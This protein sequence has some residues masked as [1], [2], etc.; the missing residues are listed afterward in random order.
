[1]YKQFYMASPPPRLS[2]FGLRSYVSQSGLAGVLRLIREKGVPTA[3]SRR[4]VKRSRQDSTQLNTAYGPLIKSFNCKGEIVEYIDPAALLSHTCVTCHGFSS[5]METKLRE[6]PSDLCNQWGLII[7]LDEV[8]PGNQLRHDN[9]RKIYAVYYSFVQFG[10]AA[11][12]CESCWMV[13]MVIRSSRVT[14]LGGMGD[15]FPH[16]LSCFFGETNLRTGVLLNCQGTSRLICASLQIV[17]ADEAAL[18]SVWE[19]KGSG[20][21]LPCLFC[22]NCVLDRSHL[23]VH[24]A[25][26]QLF[27]LSEPDRTKFV[28][29]DD[30]SIQAIV[31]YLSAQRPVLSNAGFDRLE[32]TLGFNHKPDGVLWSH[33]F[34]HVASPIQNTMYDWMHT[35]CVHGIYNIEVGLLLKVLSGV[36]VTHVTIHQ[37]LQTVHWPHNISSRA[38]SGQNAFAKRPSVISSP[39]ACSASEALGIYSPIRL[40][41]INNVL[42]LPHLRPAVTKA[43]HSYFCLAEVLDHLRAVSHGKATPAGLERAIDAHF[44]ASLDAYGDE[45]VTPKT[46][47]AVHLPEQYCLHGL[48]VNCFVHERKHR[49]LKRFGNHL[50]NTSSHFERTLIESILLCQLSI[51]EDESEFP[52]GPLLIKPCLAPDDLADIVQSTFGMVGPVLYSLEAAVRTSHR[53]YADDVVLFE[54][55]GDRRAGQ[56]WFHTSI[57]ATGFTCLELWETLGNNQFRPTQSPVLIPSVCILD[58]CVWAAVNDLFY[59]CPSAA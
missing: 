47:Y 22:S 52:T 23:H 1:M 58:T 10:A 6:H 48:L 13:L 4:S 50:F 49:E 54:I 28:R 11:L 44:K 40:F 8:S 18:K 9:R 5:F 46:H 12:S 30:A 24:D 2:E 59:I 45:H 15:I 25:H 39:L 3:V 20:G 56:V 35:Y 34:P 32:Q 31:H 55:E 41:L 38:V 37:F 33:W 7:Y 26:A 57:G 16:I 17:V 36:G 29:H 19:N 42:S 51:L 27:P 21:T 14:E 53:C 43:C